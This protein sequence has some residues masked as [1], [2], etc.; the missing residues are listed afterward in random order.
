M[1]SG[2]SLNRRHVITGVPE[3]SW[4]LSLEEERCLDVV[5]VGDDDFAVRFYGYSDAFRGPIG[6]EKTLWMGTPVANW[7]K[8]RGISLEEAGLD[9][10]EDLQTAKLFPMIG[11]RLSLHPSDSPLLGKYVQWLISSDPEPNEE[12]KKMW[13]E[14][15]R[16]SAREL[17]QQANL[18][19]LYQQRRR[20]AER[21][22]PVMARHGT[23]SLFYK[24]DISRSAKQYAE[25]GLD[26]IREEEINWR[27]DR[28]LPVHDQMFRSEVFRL[29][30]D[31]DAAEQCRAEAFSRLG[32]LLVEPLRNDPVSPVCTVLSDQIVWARS[33]ARID[34]AGGW[35]DTPPHCLEHGGTV[36]NIAFNLNGQPPVQAFVRRTDELVLTVRSIDL[37][38]KETLCTY[39]DVGRWNGV[40]SGFAIA[41]AAFALVGFH[42]DFNK[43]STGAACFQSLEDQLRA[44][45][46]GIEVSLLAALPKG[47]GMGTS[48]VLAGT[49]L[50]GLADF[51]G[52]GWDCVEIARR[53]SGLEQ[54]LGSGG[55]WQDQYGG[56]VAGAKLIET[57]PGLLQ[58]A[59]IRRAPG[60]FFDQAIADGKMLLYYTGIT[61]VAHNV[62]GEIVRNLFLN[63][64]EVLAFI[65]AIARNGRAAFEAAQC[66]DW[67]A[68]VEVVRK[69]WKLNQAL[70]SGTNPPEVQAVIDRIEGQYAALKL[71]GAGGGGYMLILANDADQA[72]VIRK[73]LEA[74]PPNPR[75]RFVNLELSK[76]GLQISRS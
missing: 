11:S 60:E 74:D 45:G 10:I 49:L 24:L 38:L 12:F 6:S 61:R 18:V 25:A 52:L 72:L 30:G 54:M 22:L 68:F 9:P 58:E 19:R 33:P 47:S 15:N 17:G 8:V 56:L 70:D 67:P 64:G 23:S 48:S 37:G 65:D 32:D 42:P 40:G 1:P 7:F 35:S 59:I 27:G 21:A 63:R 53:V 69:S 36:F 3:N 75:A 66:D 51:C 20:F 73:E 46:G 31:G 26:L 13:L 76:T 5:A 34:I 55:G 4:E 29:R 50:G 28:L 62:L 44:F 16:L 71:A 39:D 43:Q 41:R 2:W 14:A 57:Q